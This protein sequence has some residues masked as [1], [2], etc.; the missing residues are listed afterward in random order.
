MYRES[1]RV[2]ACPLP[3]TCV[4]GSD[5]LAPG[6]GPGI[7]WP[8]LLPSGFKVFPYSLLASGHCHLSPSVRLFLF[9]KM[10]RLADL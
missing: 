6:W 4:C 9:F 2:F 1:I 5:G 10:S 7:C 8:L 3:W